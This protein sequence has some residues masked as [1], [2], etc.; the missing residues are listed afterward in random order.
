METLLSRIERALWGWPLLI[1]LLGAG[2]WLML[3]LR[4]APL[5]GLPKA[6]GLLLRKDAGGKGVSPFGALCTALSG[7]IGT[8]NMVGVA[9][10]LALGGPGALLWMELSAFTGLSLKYVEGYLAIRYRRKL[11]DGSY[12]GGPFSYIRQGLGPKA[13]P[14]AR[15]FSFCG[16]MAGIC[17]V[18]SLVQ[19]SSVGA[20]LSAWLNRSFGGL[21]LLQLPGEAEAGLGAAVLGLAMA[22]LGARAIFGGMERVSRLASKLVPLMGGAYVLLCLWI[23]LRLRDRLP[24]VLSEVW[25]G[26]FH[27]KALGGGLLGTVMAGVSR[28]VFSN[29]AG[30]GTAPIAAASARNISAEEQGLLS[31]TATVFDTWII[32]TLTGLVLLVTGTQGEGVTALLA[33]FAKGLPLPGV[34]SGLLVLMLLALFAFTTV[35]GWSCCGTACL[36]DLTGDSAPARKAYLLLYLL[37]VVLAPWCSVRGVWTAA[38]ICNGLMAIPN[39]TALLLLTPGREQRHTVS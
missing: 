20:C 19:V 34:V 8:G 5:L 36:D 30:L 15:C 24:A 4:F 26:A 3:R 13:E 33:A 2:L 25:Q 31:M 16:A 11:P 38:N 7:T 14:L 39:L 6:L 21:T 10:A 18:G 35:L 28:G 12:V 37:T 32:C 1:L 23:L 9:T 27:P 22:L 17:G 29:E